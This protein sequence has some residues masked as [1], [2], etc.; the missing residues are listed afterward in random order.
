MLKVKHLEI[1]VAHACNLACES[2][3]HYSDHGHKGIVPIGEA[4]RWMSQWSGRISLGTFSLVGGE[5]TIH[6]DLTGFVRLARRH[7]PGAYL[8][9]VTNGFFLHKHPELPLALQG[10]SKAHLFLSIHHRSPEYL[11]KIKSNY[12]LLR[13]SLTRTVPRRSWEKCV[14]KRCP[15][16]FEA[17]L[18]KCSPL[19]YLGMQDAKY[20]LAAKWRPYLAYRPLEPG[21]TD[22]ELAEFFAREE[23][24]FCAM[25]PAEPERFRLPLPL[26]RMAVP[27][28]EGADH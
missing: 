19:A 14:A 6:P 23:E 3:S 7:W 18:W 16:L 5:P 1:H 28:R 25:C 11:E 17:K 24:P 20:G 2:C 10:D 22:A 26:R 21:C 13:C 27:A 12:R 8:R 15:Q 9:L 4:D